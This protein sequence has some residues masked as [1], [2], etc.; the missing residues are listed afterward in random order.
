M[1]KLVIVEKP[2][3]GKSPCWKHCTKS[4]H[5]MLAKSPKPDTL[6]VAPNIGLEICGLRGFM[7]LGGSKP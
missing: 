7:G 1:L 4:M 2:R 3:V 5:P 6:T